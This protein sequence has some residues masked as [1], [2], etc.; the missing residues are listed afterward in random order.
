MNANNTDVTVE[1]IYL[2]SGD[3][4]VLVAEVPYKNGVLH[5]V[6]KNYDGNRTLLSEIPYVNGKVNGTKRSYYE[7]GAIWMESQVENDKKEGIETWYH[8]NGIVAHHTTFV[9]GVP[10]KID[11][12][13]RDGN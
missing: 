2:G 9:N 12:V 13:S 7:S 10:I 3:S 1:K 8:P 11:V 6:K 5:G 4:L